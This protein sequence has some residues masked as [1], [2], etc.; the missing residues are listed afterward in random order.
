VSAWATRSGEPKGG[1]LRTGRISA[2]SRLVFGSRG[3]AVP[4]RFIGEIGEER[5]ERI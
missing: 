3:V 4:S 1:S 2:R 5:L